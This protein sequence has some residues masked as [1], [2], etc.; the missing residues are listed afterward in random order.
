MVIKKVYR[1]LSLGLVVAMFIQCLSGCSTQTTDTSSSAGNLQEEFIY[2]SFIYEE[3]IQE[4]H[5]EESYIVEHLIYEDGLYE[6]QLTENIVSQAYVVELVVSDHM[7]EDFLAQLPDDIEGCDIDWVAVAGKFAV[8]TSII[9]ASGVICVATGGSTFFTFVSPA[10]VAKDAFFG[11]V[12]GAILDSVIE[13]LADGEIP[14]IETIEFDI[15]GAAAGYMWGAIEAVGFSALSNVKRLAQFKSVT[16]GMLKINQ[17]GIVFSDAGKRIGQAL[18]NADGT[19]CLVDELTNTVRVFNSAGD[20]IIATAAKAL[21]AN[22]KLGSYIGGVVVTHYTDDMGQIFRIGD[23]LVPNF[24]GTFNGAQIKTDSL[25]RL[26]SSSVETL[27]LKSE[28]TWRKYISESIEVIGKGSQQ[29]GDQRGH[30]IADWFGGDNTMANLVPMSA[31]ANQGE[32]KAIETSLAK[33]LGLGQEVSLSI[34]V[35]YKGTSFRPDSFQ[36]IYTIA[37]EVFTEIIKNI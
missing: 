16:G 1:Y 9:I 35:L 20:E 10:K 34:D 30:L 14:S 33:A 26:T 5:L 32:I 25:G 37:G 13:S 7:E 27:A 11:A 18:F 19:W 12:I 23:N 36:Y 2:E 22:A 15:E 29:V 6:Y 8:G 17:Q 4:E 31:Q 28:G 21:P 3:E 24:S